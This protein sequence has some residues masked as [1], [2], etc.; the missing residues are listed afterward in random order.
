[1]SIL[2]IGAGP[3]PALYAA[4]D[5]YQSLATWAGSIE[6]SDPRPGATEGP[7][8]LAVVSNP[9][10]IERGASWSHYLHALS[11]NLG[12][13]APDIARHLLYSVEIE[14]FSGFDQQQVHRDRRLAAA[15]QIEAEFDRSDEPISASSARRLAHDERLGG[16]SAFDL[17]VLSNMPTTADSIELL[18]P[19]LQRLSKALTPG[20]VLVIMG[21]AAESYDSLWTRIDELITNTA[22]ER[23]AT[24]SEPF[25]AQLELAQAEIIETHVRRGVRSWRNRCS[26]SLW[27]EIRSELPREL[28]DERRPFTFPQFRLFAWRRRR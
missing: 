1:M 13:I 3:A 12:Q 22:L 25:H 18:A 24:Q 28:R 23:L 8:S 17:I 20:G 14:D 27:A 16:V 2:E 5:Y 10:A 19:E 4:I 15:R 7:L 21:S 26:P 9:V 11:E 6:R